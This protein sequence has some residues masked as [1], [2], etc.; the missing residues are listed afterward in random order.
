MWLCWLDLIP[1][2]ERSWVWLSVGHMPGSLAR[3]CAPVRDSLIS[4]CLLLFLPPFPL[5]ENKNFKKCF[6]FTIIFERCFCVIYFLTISFL[7]ALWRSFSSV[8]Y[9]PYYLLENRWPLELWF[10]F[11]WCVIFLLLLLRFSLSLF[12]SSL[13]IMCLDMALYLSCSVYWAFWICKFMLLAKF[14]EF[15]AIVSLAF[16]A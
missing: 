15:L 8:F 9:H 4:V 7:K 16:S 6:Y 2:T 13:I 3:A 5:S 10:T 11:V 12:F 1:Q 14:G